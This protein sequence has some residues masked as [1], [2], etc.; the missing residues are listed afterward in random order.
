[1]IPAMPKIS[2]VLVTL[3]GYVAAVHDAPG[4][5]VEFDAHLKAFKPVNIK[6]KA[7]KR[8]AART[9]LEHMLQEKEGRKNTKRTVFRVLLVTR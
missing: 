7:A 9:S 3:D 2:H 8:K 4:M 5:A 6:A 1:M